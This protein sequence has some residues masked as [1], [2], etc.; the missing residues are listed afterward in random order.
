MVD[1]VLPRA[2]DM[3]LWPVGSPPAVGPLRFMKGCLF[4]LASESQKQIVQL[5][6]EE[7]L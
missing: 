4:L 1:R 2:F 7:T 5:D 6:R 3:L